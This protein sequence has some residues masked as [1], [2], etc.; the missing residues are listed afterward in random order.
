[1][2]ET[3]CAKTSTQP[4]IFKPLAILNTIE[5]KAAFGIYLLDSAV[6]PPFTY[7]DI[8]IELFSDL[9]EH[10]EA[11]PRSVRL[12]MAMTLLAEVLLIVG[13]RQATGV[14]HMP[15][16]LCKHQDCG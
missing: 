7:V 5:K 10:A 11:Q 8:D 6:E 15:S 9:I 13:H 3:T 12:V 16:P 4:S 1:M 14:L 2:L